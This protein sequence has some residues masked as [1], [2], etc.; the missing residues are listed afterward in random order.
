MNP[1]VGEMYAYMQRHF[2]KQPMRT[3]MLTESGYMDELYEGNPLKCYEMFRM[4][5]PLLIHL[6]D[7]LNQH[8][9]LRDGQG[10]VNATQEIAMLLYIFGHN[11]HY[12][13]ISD[14]FQH[15]TETVSH[16]F[17]QVLQAVHSYAKHLI[18]PNPNVVYFPEHLQVNK[19]WSW[20]EIQ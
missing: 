19:Y 11:T 17:R 10:G 9:Y 6:M 13:C 3:S 16:H 20:F 2:D 15:S 4:T 1:L 8:G 14:R 7:K 12:R 18:K 5:R